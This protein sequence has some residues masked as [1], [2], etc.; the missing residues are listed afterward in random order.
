MDYF[1]AYDVIM[2]ISDP[3]DSYTLNATFAEDIDYGV[4]HIITSTIYFL[5]CAIGLISNALALYVA[6]RYV[7]LGKATNIF[8]FN[9]VIGDLL[10]MFGLLF[11]AFQQVMFYWPFDSFLCKIVMMMDFINPLAGIFFI[12]IMSIGH[13]VAVY[14]PEKSS[15]CQRLEVA[16]VLALITWLV[17]FFFVL[18]VITFADANG[19]NQC[20]IV[21]PEPG[22]TWDATYTI[23]IFALGFCL[24][25][26]VSVVSFLILLVK[27][28]DVDLS[29]DASTCRGTEGTKLVV[30][31]CVVFIL[32]WLP[33]NL[34]SIFDL[35]VNLPTALV[36]VYDFFVILTYAKSCIYPILYKCLSDDFR[37]GFQR[38]L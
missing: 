26:W 8:I 36:R 32:C 7:K 15:V 18:P 22:I 28:K 34:L 4:T 35:T 14:F 12:M 17:A 19:F 1:P 20:T 5:I 29:A 37:K 31:L 38:V 11:T 33:L 6:L 3:N 10:V 30:A 2:E 24:P 21:W 23:T 16:K 13:C 27:P 9:L 25:V